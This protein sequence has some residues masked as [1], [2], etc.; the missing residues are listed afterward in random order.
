MTRSRTD[1]E[2]G[3]KSSVTPLCPDTDTGNISSVTQ[4]C[5]DTDTGNKSN[6]T[7][8][9]TDDVRTKNLTCIR[10]NCTH[11][12]DLRT[13]KLTHKDER[14]GLVLETKTVG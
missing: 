5:K 10:N 12:D 14:E 7:R 3:K 1:T 13:E 4:S 8:L 11:G 2:T 6:V 9:S